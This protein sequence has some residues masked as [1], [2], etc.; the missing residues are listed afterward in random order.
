MLNDSSL[1]ILGDGNQTRDFIYIKDAVATNLLAIQKGDNQIFNISS[2]TQTSI[3]NLIDILSVLHGK[4]IKKNFERP[5]SG[6]IIHSLLLNPKAKS[7]LG[8]SQKF[9][10]EAGLKETIK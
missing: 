7:G 1:T 8:W 10:L 6:D 5:R 9:T 3:T 4:E 2:N